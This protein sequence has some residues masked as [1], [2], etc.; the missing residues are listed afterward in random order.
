M[1]SRIAPTSRTMSSAEVDQRGIRHC[2]SG[3]VLLGEPAERVV[4]GWGCVDHVALPLVD[5]PHRDDNTRCGPQQ[6]S[7]L[8]CRRLDDNA[9]LLTQLSHQRI[10]GPF[11]RL[12]VAAGQVPQTGEVRPLRGAAT[13][14]VQAVAMQQ[15]GGDLLCTALEITRDTLVHRGTSAASIA[16][17]VYVVNVRKPMRA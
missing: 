15:P 14:Q 5:Q 13:Q 16:H 7:R 1:E 8:A 9:E 12:Y 17:W 10:G 11:A 6:N 3:D 2:K 4:L